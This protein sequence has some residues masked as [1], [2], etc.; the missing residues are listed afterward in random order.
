MAKILQ[1]LLRYC[2]LFIIFS[3]RM[4]CIHNLFIVHYPNILLRISH[5]CYHF[6]LLA[7]LHIVYRVRMPSCCH[8]NFTS[9][10]CPIVFWSSFA[11]QVSTGGETSKLA[12]LLKKVL[13]LHLVTMVV[14]Y[15]YL[16]ILQVSSSFYAGALL[17][18]P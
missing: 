17:G 8:I 14:I 7:L 4:N 1:V 13:T 16:G 6:S 3:M 2:G 9:V 12:T 11:A 18:L 15:L 10:R 5:W